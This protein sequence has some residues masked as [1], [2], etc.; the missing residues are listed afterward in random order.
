M[1]TDCTPLE[2]QL[3]ALNKEQLDASL[4]TTE[5]QRAADR[6]NELAARE[7]GLKGAVGAYGELISGYDNGIRAIELPLETRIGEYEEGV[8]SLQ[9]KRQE[10]VAELQRATT[11]ADR[12]RVNNNIAMTDLAIREHE[13]GIQQMKD[14]MMTS[15][16]DLKSQREEARR[17]LQSHERQLSELQPDLNAS[18]QAME[19]AAEVAR[20]AF[21]RLEELKGLVEAKQRQIDDCRKRKDEEERSAEPA[22]SEPSVIDDDSGWFRP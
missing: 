1:A 15:T 11:T 19:D 8:K 14:Q 17:D 12:D 2:E 20:R 18:A 16:A 6:L 13:L 21:E 9:S 3:R 22:S 4:R 5:E 10:H 7:A